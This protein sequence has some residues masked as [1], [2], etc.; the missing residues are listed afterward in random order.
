[1]RFI[2]LKKKKVAGR[3]NES[4]KEPMSRKKKNN[5]RE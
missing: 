1:M 4:E 2:H 3:I 5:T